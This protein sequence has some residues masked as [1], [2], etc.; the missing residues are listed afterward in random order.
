MSTTDT[1]STIPTSKPTM[2]EKGWHVS[3][4]NLAY[5]GP[6][7]SKTEAENFMLTHEFEAAQLVHCEG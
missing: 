5:Y 3:D 6:F 4:W 1:N 7:G 2:T